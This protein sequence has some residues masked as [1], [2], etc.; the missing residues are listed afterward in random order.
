MLFAFMPLF[1]YL[2]AD[3]QI[4]SMLQA[5][6][7]FAGERGE[8]KATS[9]VAKLFEGRSCADSSVAKDRLSDA[10]GPRFQSQTGL[11][12]GISKQRFVDSNLG[13]GMPTL[14]V[15]V[16]LEPNPLTSRILVRRLA[17]ARHE[18]ACTAKQADVP[19]RAWW[20]I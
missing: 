2:N 6:W 11:V 19:E 9:D 5:L 12:T 16:M 7:S 3:K 10:G 1:V 17:V 13:L 14:K 20:R 18:R 8:L 15:K 4:R